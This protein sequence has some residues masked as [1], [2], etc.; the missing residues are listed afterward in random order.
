MS[1]MW[2]HAEKTIR[3]NIDA[4]QRLRDWALEAWPQVQASGIR[5]VIF[6]RENGGATIVD[7]F[8]SARFLAALEN[9]SIVISGIDAGSQPQPDT[10]I[11]ENNAALA[12]LPDGITAE[13]RPRCN[14][15]WL[16]CDGR[17]SWD[18]AIGG[19]HS[20]GDRLLKPATVALEVGYTSSA[21]ML[22]VLEGRQAMARWPYN[23]T[24]ITVIVPTK[25][26]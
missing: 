2:R 19:T 13:F 23:D 11:N 5:D 3:A 26:A 18:R 1:D 21:K 15:G 25:M 12:N 20:S 24:M 10:F 17:I 14:A 8:I 7:K 22:V 4:D 9:G 16:D 6:Q